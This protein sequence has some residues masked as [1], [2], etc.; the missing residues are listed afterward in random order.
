MP[1]YF[2]HL[3]NMHKNFSPPMP[4]DPHMFYV[5]NNVHL[6]IHKG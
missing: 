6:M 4:H 3:D 1:I 5:H 2:S